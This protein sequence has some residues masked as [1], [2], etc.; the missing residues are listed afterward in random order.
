MIQRIKNNAF[1]MNSAILFGGSM[2]ANILNYFFHLVIGRMVSVEI[3]GEVESITSLISILGVPA[4]TLTLI[5]T[6]YASRAKADK[7]PAESREIMKYLNKKVLQYG[8]PLFFLALLF[9]PYVKNFINISNS[10][11]IILLWLMM[12]LSFLSAVSGGMLTGWQ[13]FKDSS[14]I[15]IL[16]AVIKLTSAII[17][18]KLGFE[19]NGAIGGFLLGALAA[20]I[21]SLWVLK[22]IWKKEKLSGKKEN[23]LPI[24]FGSIKKYILPTFFATLAI[25]ILGSADMV[26]AKHN[27]DALSAGQYGA[28]TIVSKIIFFATG[29]IATVL[30]SMSAEKNHQKGDSS[31]ILKQASFLIF[32]ASVSAIF[33]YFLFPNLVLGLLFGGKYNAVS[34]YLGWFA[35]LVALYSFVNLIIQYLLSINSAK[36]VYGSAAISVLLIPAILLFGNNIH[37]ILEIAI[38]A[39]I[40]SLFW[41]LLYLKKSYEPR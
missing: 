36:F 33:I 23:V 25:N 29:I 34:S 24:D 40:A 31:K 37:A 2:A 21:A 17:I 18:I 16:S 27:L 41:G 10:W 30:F 35:I 14:W 1:A 11:A 15:A 19:L 38:I 5:A 9:T 39:Q 12:L 22:L 26:L 28:L 7:N 6:K 8:L 20:Y 13:K 32:I 3:Y 4:M